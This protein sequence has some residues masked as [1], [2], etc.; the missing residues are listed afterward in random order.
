MHDHG[1]GD[2][3]QLFD[4]LS[5]F[6]DGELAGPPCE[7]IAKHMSSCAPCERYIASLRAT[8][9]T[10]RQMGGG[11]PIPSA[12]AEE[13]LAECFRAVRAKLEAGGVP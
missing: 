12:D 2:C 8:R 13:M 4:L 6:L 9:D 3:R 7:E 1:G 11:D 10:L 5:P